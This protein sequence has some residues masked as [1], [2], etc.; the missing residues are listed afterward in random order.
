MLNTWR[1]E[2]VASF[3]EIWIGVANYIPKI[4]I[5]VIIFI[6]GAI[7]ASLIGQ[8]VT[9][10]IRAIKVDALVRRTNV[11]TYFSRAGFKLDIAAFLGAL[12]KWFIIIV[13]LVSSL[14]TLGLTAVNDFLRGVLNYIPN[15][16][17]AVLIAFTGLIIGEFLEKIVTGSARAAELGKAGFLGIVTRWVVWIFA[18]LVAL[19]QL[20]IATLFSEAVLN[21]FVIALA[22]AFGL[23][24][25]LGGQQAASDVID[26]LRREIH[27]K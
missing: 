6:I 11:D 1:T 26:R 2:F 25:G 5:A 14:D 21:G 16:L 20:R 12:V 10:I 24:F 17:V 15:V 9:H 13:F 19:Y 3:N 22:I 4:L 27:D 23:A 18:I 7:V 8:L